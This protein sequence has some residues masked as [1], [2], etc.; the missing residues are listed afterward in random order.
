VTHPSPQERAHDIAEAIREKTGT[1]YDPMLVLAV[2]EGRRSH[3]ALIALVGAVLSQKP[4]NSAPP[5]VPSPPVRAGLAGG[6]QPPA[7]SG[8][9]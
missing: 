6:G 4:Q 5:A 3:P 2:L 9:L 8:G 1:R 7:T